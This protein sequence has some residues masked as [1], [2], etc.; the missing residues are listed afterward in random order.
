M[1]SLSFTTK[2]YLPRLFPARAVENMVKSWEN[3]ASLLSITVY[4]KKV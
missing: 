2:L 4:S 3:R 1:Y